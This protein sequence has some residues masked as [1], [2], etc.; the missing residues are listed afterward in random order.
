MK[1]TV[2]LLEHPSQSM[3]ARLETDIVTLTLKYGKMVLES[4]IAC[5]GAVVNKVSRNYPLVKDCFFRFFNTLT[6]VKSELQ[7]EPDKMLSTQLR[8]SLLRALFTV[9]LLC[10][11]FDCSLFQQTPS[12]NVRDLV[13]ETLMFFVES[14]NDLDVRKNALSGLGFLSTRHHELLCGSRLCKFYQQLL[15]FPCPPPGLND[16]SDDNNMLAL[17]SMVLENLLTFFQEE[18]RRMLEADSRWKKVGGEESLKEMCDVASGMCSSV[19]QTY[20]PH[21]LECFYC[22]SAPVR[23]TALSLIATILRQGLIHPIQTVA[24]LISMQTDTDPNVR[25]KA[26]AQLCDIDCKFPGFVNMRAAQGLSLSYRLQFML[27]EQVTSDEFKMQQSSTNTQPQAS[28]GSIRGSWNPEADVPSALNSHLYS[29]LRGNRNQRRS[30]LNSLISLFDESNRLALSKL[31]YIADN[32]AH[33]PY[34]VQEEPLFIIHHI[35][36]LVS[37]SGSNV[38]QAVREALFPELKAA[39]ERAMQEQAQVEARQRVESEMRLKQQLQFHQTN[40]N[41]ALHAGDQLGAETHHEAMQTV[42]NKLQQLSSMHNAVSGISGLRSAALMGREALEAL[43]PLEEEEEDELALIERLQKCQATAL[44]AMR[45]ATRTSRACVL[46]LML[47]HFL[48][49]VYGVSDAKLQKYSPS[50]SAKLWER[51]LT[52][53]VGVRFHPVMC[54]S[55]S[56]QELRERLQRVQAQWLQLR[57]SDKWAQLLRSFQAGLQESASYGLGMSGIT[58]NTT[59]ILPS[60]LSAAL[61]QH[62]SLSRQGGH[63]YSKLVADHYKFNDDIPRWQD[64]K[65]SSPSENYDGEITTLA[66]EYLEFRKLILT[67]DP[68][69]DE[70]DAV[71]APNEI[72]SSSIMTNNNRSLIVDS[73]LPSYLGDPNFSSQQPQLPT[74]QPQKRV[75]KQTVSRTL[76]PQ[77]HNR[78]TDEE[79]S[80]DSDA[81]GAS[82]LMLAQSAPRPRS[83][84]NAPKR[85][86]AAISRTKN[87]VSEDDDLDDFYGVDCA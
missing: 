58:S 42:A 28:Y 14:G 75:P 82:R 24:N 79:D 4:C 36:L 19:A 77:S 64:E 7:A 80:Q 37:I 13:F 33:F 31:V 6:K 68:Q 74:P 27:Y 41:Q 34:Q 5:L 48:K 11:H 30:F 69:N 3:I 8:S 38:L 62:E 44:P 84:R 23:L 35:D 56:G 86:S 52:R 9:G 40:M 39:L 18:E 66:R 71:P 55:V 16:A 54:L 21:I 70:D 17:K 43:G 73:A 29:M 26:D 32:V 61:Q 22:V 12:Q 25:V 85:K 51:P 45:E 72:A 60:Q 46:L 59:G 78:E 81:G 57:K 47:K 83:S 65:D 63:S 53:R 2:P 20:L 1:V 67:I 76:V 87:M 10:K 50:D 49:D 15:Q